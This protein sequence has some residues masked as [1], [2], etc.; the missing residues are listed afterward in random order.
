LLLYTNLIEDT[1]GMQRMQVQIQPLADRLA[2][3]T[4]ARASTGKIRGTCW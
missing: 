3:K 4:S 2:Y 1:E